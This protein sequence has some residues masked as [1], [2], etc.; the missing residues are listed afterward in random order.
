MWSDALYNF[1]I[2]EKIHEYKIVSYFITKWMKNYLEISWS[3]F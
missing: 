1:I 3:N 2:K